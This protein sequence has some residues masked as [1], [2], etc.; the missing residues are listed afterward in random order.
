MN[1]SLQPR[2]S[3][4]FVM[5]MATLVHKLQQ[6]WDDVNCCSF[7][8]ELLATCSGDKTVRVYSARDFSELSFSPLT[9]H[10]YGVHCCCISPCGTYLA[11]C[12]TDALIILWSTTT[13]AAMAKLEQPGRSPVRV[14][15]FSPDSALLLSGASDGTVALWGVRE[16]RLKR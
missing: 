6:H 11:S 2:C 1:E 8:R 13:G 12:S 16:K 7:S 5:K 10:G 14:C 4:V 3:E 15:C 9:G